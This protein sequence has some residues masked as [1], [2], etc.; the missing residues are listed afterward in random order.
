MSSGRPVDLV[1]RPAGPSPRRIKPPDAASRAASVVSVE[2]RASVLLVL[3]WS[4]VVLPRVIE[5][6]AAPK[7]RRS[8]GIDYGGYTAIAATTQSLLRLMV[9]GF[10]AM[11]IAGALIDERRR[12]IWPLAVFLAPWAFL[13]I[14]DLYAGQALSVEAWLYPAVT[15]ALWALRP[16][17]TCLRTLA[18]LTAIAALTS[19]AMAQLQPPSALFRMVDGTVIVEEKQIISSGMLTGFLTQPNNLGQFV[20]LGLPAIVLLRSRALCAAYAGLGIFTVVWTAS[21]SSLYAI[22]ITCGAAL[23]VVCFRA[24]T[25]RLMGGVAIAAAF[26]AV[27]ML[28]FLTRSASAY[29]GRGLIWQLSLPAWHE[30]VGLGQGAGWYREIAATSS[31]IMSTAFHGHNQFVQILVTGGVV[32]AVLATALLAVAARGALRLVATG[33]LFG[34]LFMVALAGTCLLEVSLAVVDNMAMLPVVLVPLAVLAFAEA[35]RPEPQTSDR[36]PEGSGSLAGRRERLPRGGGSGPATVFVLRDARAPE[37]N[38]QSAPQVALT[39][40]AHSHAAG[41]HTPA[42][43]DGAPQHQQRRLAAQ[44]HRRSEPPHAGPGDQDL[45]PSPPVAGA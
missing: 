12:P 25:R 33:S 38:P 13:A 42:V 45:R 15:M 22:A 35:T 3:L 8:A 11:V 9:F 16:R 20:A 29:S 44:P 19:I 2:R 28:P 4:W 34:V 30:Q 31:S 36:E 7:H 1:N 23:L 18:H 10:C 24:A 41:Q 39:A 27:A 14:R 6:L 40:A 21:R 43:P 26:G 32:Y 37:R 5:S 17:V